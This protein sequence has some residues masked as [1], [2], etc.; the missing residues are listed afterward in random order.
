MRYFFWLLPIESQRAYYQDLIDQ[1]ARTYNGP[2]F[3]PHITVYSGTFASDI[4][5]E[6][7]LAQTMVRFSPYTLQIDRLR[8]TELFTK[9]FFVQLHPSQ[10]LQALSGALRAQAL[11]PA[12]YEPDPHLSL[13]YQ[14]IPEADKQQLAMSIQLPGSHITFDE[15]SV[16]TSPIPTRSPRDVAQWQEVYRQKLSAIS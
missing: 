7:L 3:V 12:N 1:L 15:I 14:D 9:S 4:S 8:Y 6:R 10:P 16:I 11:P 13:L 2:V 5:S